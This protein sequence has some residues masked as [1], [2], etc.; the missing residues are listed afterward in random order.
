MSTQ[1]ATLIGLEIL[2]ETR[3]Q[4]VCE[5]IMIAVQEYCSA[6]NHGCDCQAKD[7]CVKLFDHM[8]A[9]GAVDRW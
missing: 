7:E 5:G 6:K 8:R 9:Y 4:V 1:V 2:R 3:G